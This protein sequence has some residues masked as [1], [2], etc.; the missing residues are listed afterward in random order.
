M[1]PILNGPQSPSSFLDSWSPFFSSSLLD[2]L[3]LPSLPSLISIFLYF[4]I[5][6]DFSI[7]DYVFSLCRDFLFY[8][9]PYLGCSLLVEGSLFMVWLSFAWV[10]NIFWM[11]K[12]LLLPIWCLFMKTWDDIID[13]MV[14]LR[15]LVSLTWLICNLEDFSGTSFFTVDSRLALEPGDSCK[16]GVS[17]SGEGVLCCVASND[18]P[19]SPRSIEAFLRWASFFVFGYT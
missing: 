11:A 15:G 16:Q 14:I 19:L 10:K 2:R 6:A 18:E 9:L 12:W 17:H 8:C 4:N 3:Y 5:C 7:V 13:A 1:R